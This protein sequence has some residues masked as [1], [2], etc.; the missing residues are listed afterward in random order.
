MFQKYG[1]NWDLRC[2]LV[3]SK[4]LSRKMTVC[5][6]GGRNCFP[7]VRGLI[8]MAQLV[9]DERADT[10]PSQYCSHLIE[11]RPDLPAS[12]ISH[13]HYVV[14]TAISIYVH[15]VARWIIFN[16]IGG[17]RCQQLGGHSRGGSM[18][19]GKRGRDLTW[20]AEGPKCF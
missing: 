8:I 16:C 19:F 7:C 11:A 13:P 18:I 4:R 9:K 10:V 6:R 12:L 3:P 15:V 17:G 14:S 5:I 20:A 1:R 2:G